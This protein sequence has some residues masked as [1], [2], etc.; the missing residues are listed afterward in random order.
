MTVGDLHQDAQVD[1]EHL[2]G[3]RK[4]ASWQC[5]KCKAKVYKLDDV[6]WEGSLGTWGPNGNGYLYFSKCCEYA[7]TPRD[8]NREA[9]DSFS[10]K[11][12]V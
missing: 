7:M 4:I 3:G 9:L 2:F 6:E 1:K 5:M 10:D 11:V 8:K 12:K